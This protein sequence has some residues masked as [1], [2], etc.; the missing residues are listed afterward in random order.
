MAVPHF[1][2]EGETMYDRQAINSLVGDELTAVWAQLCTA[3]ESRYDTDRLWGKGFGWWVH[4]YKYRRGG[5]TLCTLYVKE[6]TVCVLVTLGKAEREKFES[7]RESFSPELLEIYDATE[8]LHD[9]KWL[10]LEQTDCSMI[11]ELLR[12]LAIK[13]R[14]NVK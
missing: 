14:P 7:R 8:T 3:I 5:K 12:L 9:G 6:N 10:W 2:K 11:P 4:E 1:I 13:R